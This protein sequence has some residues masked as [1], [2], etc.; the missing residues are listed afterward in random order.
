MA[1][2]A[3]ASTLL[4]DDF[5]DGDAAG[6][7]RSGGTWT[8]VS[9]GSPVL[10]QSNAGTDNA[11]VFAGDSSW[12]DYAVQ[13]RVKPLTLG[14]T[15][16][17]ALLTRASG[18]TT[19]YRLVLLPG[20]A[21]LQLVKSGQVTVLGSAA[22]TVARRSP[23]PRVRPSPRGGLGCRPNSPPPNS[24]TWRSPAAAPLPAR[25]LLRQ[26]RPAPRR[27]SHRAN[28]P[29]PHRAPRRAR[30]PASRPAGRRRPA[31][32]SSWRRT[33]AATTPRSRPPWTPSRQV[34]AAG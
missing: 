18:S 29:A 32:R 26:A 31:T 8:V 12:S 30:H 13:A 19:F 15:G 16:S 2:A 7:S 28:P 9:D 6:W 20:Q 4:G 23:R 25:P 27:A 1:S 24:M 5:S 17:V 14:A 22:R 33:A 34:T 10:Q 21:Q 3:S 11:R